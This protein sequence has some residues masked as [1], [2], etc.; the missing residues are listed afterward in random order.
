M[1]CRSRCSSEL[2]RRYRAT[3]SAPP[4]GPWPFELG[5][6][7]LLL[8]QL[9]H[10]HAQDPS[11]PSQCATVG[12]RLAPLDAANGVAPYSCGVCQLLLA[13]SSQSAKYFEPAHVHLHTGSVL[14]KGIIAQ[15]CCSFRSIIVQF[16]CRDGN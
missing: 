9:S 7:G 2:T 1:V 14:L 16:G 15:I 12:T 5:I 4:S 11:N 13:H 8:H 10:I 3:L 6:I